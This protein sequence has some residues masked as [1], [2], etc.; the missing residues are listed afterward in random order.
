MAMGHVVPP[1]PLW[2]AQWPRTKTGLWGQTCHVSE[3]TEGNGD[4]FLPGAW[5]ELD[6]QVNL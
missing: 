1:P 3:I 6:P 2:A 4:A 5:K